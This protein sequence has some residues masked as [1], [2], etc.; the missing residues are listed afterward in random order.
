M[1]RIW[2]EFQQNVF[3]F[4]S[5][6]KGNA[7]VSAVAGSGKTATIVECAK[8]LSESNPNMSILF[9]AFNK[10]IA[11]ELSE[12]LSV[13]TNVN[14]STLHAHGLK[15]LRIFKPKIDKYATYNLG[16]DCLMQSNVFDIDA[17]AEY[18]IPFKSNCVKLYNLARINL[19]KTKEIDKLEE[20]CYMHNIEPIADE[21]EVISNLLATAYELK[22]SGKIDFTDMLTLA[23]QPFA[24][25]FIPK[26][27]FIFI[28]ECQDLSAAQREL[29]LSSL[30]KD[31]RFVAVGD[32]QQAINGFAGASN[33][34]FDLLANQPN[35]IEL[36]LSVN[37]RC[38]SKIIELAKDIVPQII[39]HDGAIDGEVNHIDNLKNLK[40]GDMILCRKSAPLISLCLKL[41]ANDTKAYVKG[42]DLGEGL[43]NLIKRLK[44]KNLS[45]LFSKLDI[46]K[47]KLAKEIL[48]KNKRLAES[49]VSE[50]PKMIAFQDKINCLEA[51]A[52]RVSSISELNK[53]I[54]SIFDE[55]NEKNSVCLSTIHKSK[56]LEADNV[57]IVVPDKLPLVWKNQLDWQYQQEMNLKYVAYTR[58]KKTLNIVDLDESG[59]KKVEL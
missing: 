42:K 11:T 26:Y 7:A 2:N 49:E 12:K 44:P 54:D 22:E 19:V 34:S 21:V 35:T 20:L 1:E 31:G 55:M 50:Q 41:L 9:L 23:V 38:G 45:S 6:Q 14:C 10:S 59:L 5:N 24:K 58:A 18:A 40:V 36:P 33:D 29:M 57:F 32:R 16:N 48:A 4:V 15:A 56:G 27:D 53:K 28:D 13:Y 25:K 39:A 52:E 3:N 8:L 47:E 37:Y 51:I 43:K 46:E 17:K 30:K